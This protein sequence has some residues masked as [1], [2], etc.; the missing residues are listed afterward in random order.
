MKPNK[1]T[2]YKS[3][4]DLKINT[5]YLF[6]GKNKK[7]GTFYSTGY[8]SEEE[9]YDHNPKNI[10]KEMKVRLDADMYSNPPEVTHYLELEY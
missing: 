6:Y 8:I 10:K 4:K 2:E 7:G 3:I 5:P 9:L 1:L